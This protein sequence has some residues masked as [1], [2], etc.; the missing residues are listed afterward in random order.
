[1]LARSRQAAALAWAARRRLIQLATMTGPEGTCAAAGPASAQT[2]AAEELCRSI[3]Y[4]GR[5]VRGV[6]LVTL[7]V[8]AAAALSGVLA[9]P[10]TSAALVAGLS[11]S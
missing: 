11:L 5:L 6:V 10:W 1:V 9:D 3:D 2:R 8:L 4:L 7:A